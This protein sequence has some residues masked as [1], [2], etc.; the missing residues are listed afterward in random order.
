[1]IMK[2]F[3]FQKLCTNKF[4]CVTKELFS[5]CRLARS[6]RPIYNNVALQKKEIHNWMWKESLE[7]T[8]FLVYFLSYLFIVSECTLFE[9]PRSFFARNVG[10]PKW[11]FNLVF[12][13][14]GLELCCHFQR[15]N[16]QKKVLKSCDSRCGYSKIGRIRG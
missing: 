1:M 10:S 5:F 11:K 4:E 16:T 9:Q 2:R 8:S 12:S 15:K 14:S 6:S 13:S 3:F 7:K